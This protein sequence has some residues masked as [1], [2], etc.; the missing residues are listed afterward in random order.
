M[1]I[2]QDTHHVNI[3]DFGLANKYRDE[4]TLNHIPYRTYTNMTGTVR[5]MSI[6]SHRRIEHTRRDD[7]ESLAYVLI[8]FLCGSLP[9]QHLEGGS[10]KQRYRRIMQQK[11][12]TPTIELCSGLPNEFEIFLDYTRG[13]SFDAK[14]NYEY[15]RSL[16]QNLFV[17]RGYH[18]DSSFDWR[19]MDIESQ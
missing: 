15:I 5:Y 9:W 7:L 14:P 1:G 4:F 10:K 17:A 12:N 3:I 16:F 13:L 11:I 18:H 8:Y 2:H 6:N 19:W